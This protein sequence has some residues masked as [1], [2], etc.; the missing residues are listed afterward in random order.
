MTL[1][2]RLL[3]IKAGY[4]KEEIEGMSSIPS[5]E[6]DQDPAPVDIKPSDPLPEPEPK[7]P[8]PDAYDQVMSEIQKLKDA[9][10]K[11]NIQQRTSDPIP[12]AE[13]DDDILAS[14]LDPNFKNRKEL[15]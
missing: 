14:I 9:I 1:E 4:T 12:Q 11:Q 3:L 7:D 6:P 13:T 2:D 10:I 15:S 8:E 5:P